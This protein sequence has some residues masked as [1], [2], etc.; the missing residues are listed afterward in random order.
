MARAEAKYRITAEDQTGRGVRSAE[1]RLLRLRRSAIAFGARFAG[2]VGVAAAAIGGL[3]A[4]LRRIVAELD[5]AAKTAADFGLQASELEQLRVTASLLGTDLR[6]LLGIQERLANAATEAAD[7]TQEYAEAFRAL[8]INAEGFSRL[9]FRGQLAALDVGLQR[10]SGSEQI[11]TRRQL[12]GRG[13]GR[14]FRGNLR[15]TLGA[16]EEIIDVTG[17]DRAAAAA[18]RLNDA[19][20][21]LGEGISQRAAAATTRPAAEFLADRLVPVL[22][23]INVALRGSG[24]RGVV[25]LEDSQI[26]RLVEANRSTYR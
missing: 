5:E 8:G 4:G 20:A 21:L 12:T 23:D 6:S 10:L 2:G 9:S 19:L 11:A 14:I 17:L 13:T 18:E 1:S 15:E 24:N 25:R 26:D 16:A 22:E 7:G 3:V